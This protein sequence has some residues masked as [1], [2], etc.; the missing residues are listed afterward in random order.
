MAVAVSAAALKVVHPQVEN[1]KRVKLA[2]FHYDFCNM[3]LR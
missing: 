1:G 2:I 3:C